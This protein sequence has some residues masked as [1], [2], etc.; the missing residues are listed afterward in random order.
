MDK[1][2]S[3][4]FLGDVVPHK[5][6]KFRNKYK[7]VINLECPIT[8]EGDPVE[9]KIN[10]RVKENHLH[11][12]FNANLLG[13]SLGNNHIL[14]YGRKGLESTLTELKK[15]EIEW[16]GLKSKSDND[17]HPLILE[18]SNSKIAFISVVCHSTTP[19]I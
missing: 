18:I 3:I 7:T 13:V 11:S 2:N 1:N 4:L 14:D 9:G 17:F 8:N 12:I 16:F 6:Y 5:P 15:S 19:V 10:L